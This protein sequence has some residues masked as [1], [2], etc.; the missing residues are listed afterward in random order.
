MLLQIIDALNPKMSS[1]FFEKKENSNHEGHALSPFGYVQD[2][3]RR[4]GHEGPRKVHFM[5]IRD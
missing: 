1:I 3:L 4:M 5:G 2:K